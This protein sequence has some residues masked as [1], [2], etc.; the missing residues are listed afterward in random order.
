[1]IFTKPKPD[2]DTSLALQTLDRM[3][4]YA[5]AEYMRCGYAVAAHFCAL[6]RES[7][8]VQLAH[9]ERMKKGKDDAR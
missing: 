2:A 7:A 6:T 5:E 8:R 4:Q 3:M 9:D 1:M